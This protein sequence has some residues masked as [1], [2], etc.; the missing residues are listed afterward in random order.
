MRT[1]LAEYPGSKGGEGVWQR[2]ISQMPPHRVYIEPFI[3]SGVVFKRKR[4]A[5]INIGVD[6]DPGVITL[7]KTAP[8][9]KSDDGIRTF[10]CGDAISF[11]DGFDWRGDECVYCDPP[12]L[13]KTRSCKR[14]YYRRELSRQLRFCEVDD[15]WHEALLAVL[16]KIPAFVIVSG[17]RSELYADE[18]EHWRCVYVPTVTRGGPVTECL[19]CNFPEPTVLHDYRWLGSDFRERERIKKRTNRLVAK[20]QALPSLERSALL[21]AVAQLA[22]SKTAVPPAV[23]PF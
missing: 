4:A 23:S 15:A 10:I 5:A 7:H 21:S 22:P 20:L 9:A 12:Y 8:L 11:L 2:I 13:F 17:Y 16:K 19:W 3:G 1:T 18:L 14:R 6:A